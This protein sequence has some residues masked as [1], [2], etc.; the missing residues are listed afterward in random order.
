[1]TD[2][3]TMGLQALRLSQ[4]FSEMRDPS[5]DDRRRLAGAVQ[6]I[7]RAHAGAHYLREGTT[8]GLQ[9]SALTD[10][11]Y[12]R[13]TVTKLQAAKNFPE[14]SS[15][16]DSI[17]QL[18]ERCSAGDLI[19]ERDRNKLERFFSVI[20]DAMVSELIDEP[21]DDDRTGFNELPGEGGSHLIS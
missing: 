8:E 19:S 7:K 12:A 13:K 1:M 11:R 5:A 21:T 6:F 15:Y 2:T 10:A 17:E 9:D 3:L 18:L 4:F 20:G 14:F 16:L